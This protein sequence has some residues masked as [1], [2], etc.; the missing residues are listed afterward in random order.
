MSSLSDFLAQPSPSRKRGPSPRG[1]VIDLL[2]VVGICLAVIGRTPVGS[3]AWWAGQRIQGSP[4]PIPSLTATFS[5]GML[6]PPSVP[7]GPLPDE[8]LD[9]GQLPEPFRSAL[10]AALADGFPEGLAGRLA[11]QGAT[12]DAD[13]ALLAVDELYDGDAAYAVEAL[14]VGAELAA[15]ATARARAAGAESPTT[16]QGHRVYLPNAVRADADRVVGGTLAVARV[17]DLRW[18]VASGFRITSPYG[19]RVHPVLKTRKLH[20]GIDIGTPVG[21]DVVAPQAGTV[22]VA[23]TNPTSGNYLIIDHGHGVR[24]SYCHLSEH[25]AAQGD[26]VDAG[27]LIAK[28]GNTGR[29]TGPHLHYIVRIGGDTID[30]LRFVTPP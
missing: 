21:T 8:V 26:E 30:P 15:R 14:V 9:E 19:Y 10:R 22:H 16:Y 6:A 1:G 3:L 2:L 13:A 20:N 7:L 11:T 27:Q 28:T 12:A 4:V 25:V 23:A 29:S 24:T 18:P 17:L 5:H